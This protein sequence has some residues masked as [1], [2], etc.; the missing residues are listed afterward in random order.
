MLEDELRWRN[1]WTFFPGTDNASEVIDFGGGK[2]MGVKIEQADRE[3]TF[4]SMLG[5][6]RL[7]SRSCHW[8]P[9]VASCWSNGKMELNSTG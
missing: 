1:P 3:R 5:V 4:P 8:P 7:I 2:E 6:I 9:P